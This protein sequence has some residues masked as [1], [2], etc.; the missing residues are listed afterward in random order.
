MQG[1][2]DTAKNMKFSYSR[3][4]WQPLLAFGLKDNF[5]ARPGALNKMKVRLGPNAKSVVEQ[6]VDV[7]DFDS[8]VV[9]GLHRFDNVYHYY[10]DMCGA[11]EQCLRKMLQQSQINEQD[12]TQ[13]QESK[14][15]GFSRP[16][17]YVHAADD[18]IIHVDTVPDITILRQINNLV[19]LITKT[20]GHVGWPIG[21]SP[22]RHRWKF[23]N[24]LIHEFCTAI[25]LQKQDM[26]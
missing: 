24:E 12:N 13:D 14:L 2:F 25:A 20:G 23:Q 6:V 7:I 11:S 22:W 10:S 19:C 8:V 21:L 1:C 17:L 9:T 26:R 16:L 15:C 18:P 4:I 5:V 3:N